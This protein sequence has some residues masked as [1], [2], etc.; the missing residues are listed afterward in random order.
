MN[1]QRR[2]CIY[3]HIKLNDKFLSIEGPL[4]DTSS[5]AKTTVVYNIG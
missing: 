5:V 4:P 3:L 1:M 2:F